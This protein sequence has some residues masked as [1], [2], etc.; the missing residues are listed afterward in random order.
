MKVTKCNLVVAS[1][2]HHRTCLLKYNPRRLCAPSFVKSRMLRPLQ[3]LFLLFQQILFVIVYIHPGTPRVLPLGFWPLGQNPV[4]AIALPK[5]YVLSWYCFWNNFFYYHSRIVNSF[6]SNSH[7]HVLQ[8]FPLAWIV[9]RGALHVM[10]VDDLEFFR[11]LLW[12][13]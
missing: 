13:C 1:T 2:R 7:C 12:I 4:G 6:Q 11:N 8:W 9:A 10:P 5:T 3:T